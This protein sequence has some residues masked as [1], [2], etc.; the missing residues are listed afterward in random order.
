VLEHKIADSETDFIITLDDP[1]LYSVMDRLLGATRLKALIVGNLQEMSS[2]APT[3][4]MLP[5]LPQPIEWDATHISFSQLLDN[6]RQ[7]RPVPIKDPAQT[8][9][10]LQYTGGTTGMP[11]GAMLTHANLAAAAGQALLNL[12]PSGAGLKS[13]Q[14][15][16][17]VTLPLFHIYSLT[18]N[19]LLGV[20]LAARLILHTRFELEPVI[21]DLAE[22]RVT[23]F[24][25]VPTMFTAIVSYTKVQ[26]FDLSALRFSNSGGAPLPVEVHQRFQTLTNCRLQEG[27]GMT[28]T[29]GVGTNTPAHRSHKIGSCGVPLCGVTIRFVSADNPN[30]AVS[31]GSVGEICIAGPNVMR[32]YW[33]NPAATA[34]EM[35]PDGFLR[36]GD[37]GSMDSDGYL[38]IVDRIKD[39][40]LCSGYNVYPRNIEEA[41]YRHPAV[42]EVLVVGVDDAYRG[43]SPK[44]FVTL[45]DGAI[46]PTLEAM[47]AFLKADLGKH[48]MIQAMEIRTEL[49]RTNVGKLSRK[50][51]FDEEKEKARITVA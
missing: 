31:Y 27:W 45:Q 49:P 10:V 5:S 51:L 7:Y 35:L 42:A 29:C 24:F 3:V 23:V 38:W 28:E 6:N 37:V 39:M 33:K 14:E 30:V 34:A 9:A 13:G 36:T 47:K 32:G 2:V 16:L 25:G 43:Q 20:A 18:F 12:G 44:A 15:T 22:K 17:L 40:I 48:E 21:R 26:E 19:L 41:I 46:A 8:I 1:T 4:A 50:I 11:K